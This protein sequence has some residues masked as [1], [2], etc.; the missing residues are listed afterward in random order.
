MKKYFVIVIAAVVFCALAMPA[1]ADTVFND[2]SKCVKSWGKGCGECGG[3]KTA[4]APASVPAKG[5]KGCCMK[6]DVLGNKV[7]TRTR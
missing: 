1:C 7:C 5:K 6:T 2:M 4:A 3:D